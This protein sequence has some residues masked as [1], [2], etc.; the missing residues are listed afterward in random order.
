MKASSPGAGNVEYYTT[1]FSDSDVNYMVVAGLQGD[2]I[3]NPNYLYHLHAGHT[4]VVA[5][6]DDS[7]P[8]DR[9][10]SYAKNSTNDTPTTGAIYVLDAEPTPVAAEI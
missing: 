5:K 2:G 8:N 4:I 3:S 1:D 7:G 10:Y 6:A 9:T